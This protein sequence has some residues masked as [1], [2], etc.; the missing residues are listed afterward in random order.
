MHIRETLP[1][2]EP[3]LSRLSIGTK[4]PDIKPKKSR[5]Q[6]EQFLSSPMEFLPYLPYNACITTQE[7]AMIRHL[8]YQ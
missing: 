4:I 5:K 6:V 8:P 1:V 7:K 2:F 3:L